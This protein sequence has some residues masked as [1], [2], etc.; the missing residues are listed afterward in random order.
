MF[1]KILEY[2]NT[3][4][5]SYSKERELSYKVR[6]FD[7]SMAEYVSSSKTHD[8]FKCPYCLEVRGKEDNDGK[9][10][11]SKE[12]LI[13][14]CFKCETVG[15]LK[16]DKERESVLFEVKLKGLIK[17][18][19]ENTSIDTSLLSNYNYSELDI[20]N[21]EALDY[22]DSRLPIYKDFIDFFNFRCVEGVGLTVPI[23]FE[24]RIISYN[25][26]FYK[27]TG[28]MKYYIPDGNKFL[29]NPNNSLSK[30][31]AFGEYTIVEG[32]FD[33]IGALLLGY[34]NPIAIFGKSMTEFQSSLLRRYSPSKINIFLDETELS[35]KLKRNIKDYFPTVEEYNIIPA[36]IDPEERL[37][38]L[39]RGKKDKDL[40]DLIDNMI[41]SI[42]ENID[43]VSRIRRD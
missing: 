10:Y 1:E 24:D 38:K 43:R 41:N 35:K 7:S 15:I 13:G 39:L 21:Q 22:L 16:T 40:E 37:I 4:K 2:V 6:E 19:R 28:K 12:K 33:A 5:K 23:Y 11:W 27:P 34:K 30:D 18:V 26:R 20:L 31:K 3:P 42:G 32:T 9:F 29:Y 25:L 17:S 14:Y 36:K 8:R